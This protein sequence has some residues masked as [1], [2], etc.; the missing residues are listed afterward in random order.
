M[1]R[2]ISLL[3]VIA[4][5]QMGYTLPAQNYLKLHRQAI[6]CDTHNDIVSVCVENGYLFD[7]DLSRKTH[8]DLNR[9]LAGGLDAQVFSIFC[10][11][12]QKNPYLFALQEIDSVYAW[13]NRNPAKMA[14]AT[15]VAQIKHNVKQHKLSALIGV[16]GG[17]MIE[18]D[19]TKLENLFNRGARYLT[20]T[21]NNN[22]N[23]GTSAAYESGEEKPVQIDPKQQKGLN[24]FGVTVVK[25]MNELG[26]MIDLS[27][28]GEQT[29]WDVMKIATKPVIV[30]HSNAYSL[31]PVYRNLKD[32]QIKAIAKNNGVIQL[33]FYSAFIDSAAGPQFVKFVK[34]H[35][36]EKDSLIKTGLENSEAYQILYKRYPAEAKTFQIPLS[37]LIDHVDYIVKLAGINHVGLGGDFDGI[38]L[39]PIELTDVTKYPLITKA[40]LNRGYSKKEVKKIL[41]NNFLRVLKANESKK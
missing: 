2:I 4:L 13:V 16:E 36:L 1:Q 11:G 12:T 38:S 33:N 5:L 10:D 15:T 17:H 24:E 40:L 26:M 8:S 28:V 31:C 29:F 20:L 41:G 25:K 9:M 35:R 32:D 34:K 30:S 6:V 14:L 39:T 7:A 23:W 18:N 3:L 37:K 27:H 19:L 21:W 22:T